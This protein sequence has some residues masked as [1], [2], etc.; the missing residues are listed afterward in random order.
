MTLTVVPNA[1]HLGGLATATGVTALHHVIR[2][3]TLAGLNPLGID[4]LQQ[5]GVRTIVDLRTFEERTAS[6]EPNLGALGFVQRWLPLVERDPAPLGVHLEHGF[7]GYLWM[8]QNFLENGRKAL[9]QLVQTVSEAEG[10]VLYHCSLG[11]DR[12][13]VA[14]AVLLSL[15]GATDEAIIADHALSVTLE[16]LAARGITGAEAEQRVWAPQAGMAAL[17]E[18]VRE[19][20]G[21]VEGYLG[22]AGG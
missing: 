5:M 2:S 15:H 21:G 17:L 20:W 16:S 1:R 10:G 4:A 14:T 9:A 22:E 13:A 7:A 12:T 19:R 11:Q 18:M 8:Y 3:G 6:P